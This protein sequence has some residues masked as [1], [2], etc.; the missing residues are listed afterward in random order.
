MAHA[1]GKNR[2]HVESCTQAVTFLDSLHR[3][4]LRSLKVTANCVETNLHCSTNYLNEHN[5][6]A[7]LPPNRLKNEK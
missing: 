2:T 6:L 3:E 5:Q 1:L 7:E 4:N